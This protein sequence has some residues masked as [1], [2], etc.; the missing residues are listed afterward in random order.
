MTSALSAQR[1]WIQSGAVRS[2]EARR[3]ALEQ[4]ARAIRAAEPSLLKALNEDLGKSAIDAYTSEIGFVLRDIAHAQAHLR[5]WMKGRRCPVP[6][7]TWMARAKSLPEPLGVVLILGPWNYPF[8]LMMSPLVSALAAGN[9][10]CLKPSEL[11]PETARVI[12]EICR[13]AFDPAH[14]HVCL[15]GRDTAEELVAQ[16]FDHIFFT[17]STATGR[18]VAEQAARN[19]V[20]VTLELG[21]KSPCVVCRDAPLE[22][23]ARRILWG[24][25]LNAGQTCV[26]PDYVLVEKELEKPLLEALQKALRELWPDER[27]SDSRSH[28]V[29][30]PHFDRLVRLMRDGTIVAGGRTDDTTLKMETTVLTGVDPA[31]PIM[32]EEIFGPLLPVLPVDSFEQACEF[33]WARPKPLAAYLFCK[34][35]SRM[36][37]FVRTI[38][39]GTMCMNDTISQILPA[40][41]PFGGVGASGMGKYRG[42]QGFLTFSNQKAVMWRSLWPDPHFRYKPQSLS[43]SLMK[44]AYSWMMK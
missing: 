43:L 17:G 1:E 2:P 34:E 3:S 29:S 24:K 10:A 7:V 38:S 6:L 4:F 23:T 28:I 30:R 15:G 18:L 32:Q 16:P 13:D 20:P 22:T 40:E 42:E 26:A 33:I 44:K 14:V 8:Q 25:V 5:S 27:V 31:K 39:A 9:A 21:G 36:D 11:A 19:L 12:D 41:L 35:K 37:T